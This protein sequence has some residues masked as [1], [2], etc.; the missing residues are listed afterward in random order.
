M[1]KR[2]S[3]WNLCPSGFVWALYGTGFCWALCGPCMGL[4]PFGDRG[5]VMGPVS[6]GLG[7]GLVWDWYPYRDYGRGMGLF[8]PGLVWAQYG[9]N[10]PK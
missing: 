9:T 4:V 5:L 7:V 6:M 10:P 3:V 2:G 8:L 1:L